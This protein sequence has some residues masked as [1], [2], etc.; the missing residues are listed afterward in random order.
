VDRDAG[1]R[2]IHNVHGEIISKNR[3]SQVASLDMA[4]LA[5]S[6]PEQISRMKGWGEDIAGVHDASLGR[7]PQGV[8]TGIGIA[9]LKQSDSVAQDD[10]VDNLEDFLTDV[11]FKILKKV[12]QNVSNYQVVRDLGVREGDE[13]YFAVIGQPFA[14]GK[15]RAG[16]EMGRPG[17]V[18]IGPDWF[19]VAEVGE[20]N[21]IRVTVGSWL[22][23]TKEALQQKVLQYYQ[24]GIIDQ[25]TCL[26]LLEFGDI[27]SIIQQT[28]REATLKRATTA[29]QGQGGQQTDQ[30]D[31]AMAEN[32][33]ILAGRVQNAQDATALVSPD[34]D[35]LVHVAV[36]QDALGQG[37]DAIVGALIEAHQ[38]MMESGAGM[39]LQMNQ[40][41]GQAP[42]PQPGQQ[43]QPPQG[44]V[45]PQA[46]PGPPP[47]QQL[48]Q[49]NLEAVSG[50]NANNA[51]MAL[52]G[53]GGGV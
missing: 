12:A 20:E 9:E 15:K 31:L 14:K 49:Q 4:P 2:A 51:A 37:M 23:Y 10:L 17:Q 19:D 46:P 42:M 47:G 50:Q 25:A 45:P 52:P 21:T 24:A 48:P 28:R 8:R 34:Q 11:A 22:G 39:P 27:D 3:G 7:T 41:P 18:K 35:H 53:N 36:H 38:V 40:P 30:Y 16:D 33:M 32:D 1:I 26:K 6:V 43:A 29:P 5:N 44:Q 13:K